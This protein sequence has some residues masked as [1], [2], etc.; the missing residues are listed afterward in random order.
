[1]RQNYTSERTGKR[2]SRRMWLSQEL[3]RQQ[4]W[5]E[6][7]EQSPRSYTGPNGLAIAQAD[8]DALRALEAQ[9]R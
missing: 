3:S 2:I 8:R 7:C 1:M 9:V 5:I 4:K 6:R